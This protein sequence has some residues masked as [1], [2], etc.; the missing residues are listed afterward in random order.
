[1]LQCFL[2][3]P[4]KMSLRHPLPPA[5]A[6]NG[7]DGEITA[8]QFWPDDDY[9]FIGYSNGILRVHWLPKLKLASYPK[10]GE[11]LDWSLDNYW[12]ITLHAANGGAIREIFPIDTMLGHKVITC[13]ED[14]SILVHNVDEAVEAAAENAKKRAAATRDSMLDVDSDGPSERVRRLSGDLGGAF[15]KK[16]NRL[17]WEDAAVTATITDEKVRIFKSFFPCYS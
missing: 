14:G 13:A 6:V 7:E 1:M 4:S 16:R 5:L 11:F 8:V 2:A 9:V 12:L 15:K 10:A 3:D 17:T